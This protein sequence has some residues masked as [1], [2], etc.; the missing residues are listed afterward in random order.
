MMMIK[1]IRPAIVITILFVIVTGIIYPGIVTA[2]AQVVFPH[3]AN[4][5]L[6][7]ANGQAV[8]SELIGQYWTSPK[9]FHGRPSATSPAPYQ[10][11]NTSAS[12]LGPTNCKLVKGCDVT[13]SDGTPVP[14]G[15]VPVPGQ[16]DTYHVPGNV[17]SYADQFRKDNELPADTPLPSDIVTSSASG[18]DPHISPEAANLQVARVAHVRGL[19]VNKVKQLVTDHTGGRFLWIFGEPYVNVLDLNLALDQVK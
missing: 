5:S 14:D 13:I 7:Y 6:V 15:A 11:D 4:G 1:H 10:A 16:K 17:E 2:I 3:Q 19:D 9:Y 18:L 8:G 12:N